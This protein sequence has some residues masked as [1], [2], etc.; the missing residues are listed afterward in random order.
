MSGIVDW[1]H[2]ALNAT[3]ALWEAEGWDVINPARHCG[4][5]TTR[6]RREYMRS[7]ISQLSVAHAVAVLPGWE[8]SRGACLEVLI[9]AALEIPVWDATD[10]HPADYLA[11]F[12][13]EPWEPPFASYMADCMAAPRWLPNLLAQGYAGEDA[14]ESILDEAERLVSGERGGAYSHPAHDF[15]TTARF[16]TVYADRRRESGHDLF[17]PAD[18]AMMQILL[19]LSREGHKHGRDNLTD[20]AGYARCA[21]MVHEYEANNP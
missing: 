20:I 9:A 13:V 4:G 8:A 6:P 1:N 18:V 11:D 19:K 14:G 10:P 2:P 16:W 17:E 15:A 3:A 5:D 21:Q 7:A 12:P